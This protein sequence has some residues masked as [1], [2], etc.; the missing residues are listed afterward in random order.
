MYDNRSRDLT[1][2]TEKYAW[3]GFAPVGRT[4]W[5]CFVNDSFQ[6]REVEN[7]IWRT[8]ADYCGVEGGH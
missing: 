4:R 3:V 7:V 6:E 1:I 2:G 8:N 5:K